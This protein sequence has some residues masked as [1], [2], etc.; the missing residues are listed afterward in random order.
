MTTLATTDQKRSLHQFLDRMGGE[1]GKVVSSHMT[2]ETMAALVYTEAARVPAIFD[3]LK[4]NPGS[5]A[6]TVML[7]AQLG[8]DVSGPLGHFYLIPR[9][10]KLDPRDKRRNAPKAM[11]LTYIIG[12]KGF[13]ELAR[14]SDD[15]VRPN[16]GVV[17]ADELAE[18]GGRF[19]WKDEP[20]ECDH[21]RHWGLKRKDADIVGAYALV[22]LHG[23]H[24]IQILLDR[25]AIDDRRKRAMSDVF[26]KRDFAAMARKSAIRSLMNGGEVPLTPALQKAVEADLASDRLNVLD[27]SELPASPPAVDPLRAKLGLEQKDPPKEVEPEPEPEV[28]DVDVDALPLLEAIGYLEGQLPEELREEAA[29]AAKLNPEA[30]LEGQG[31]AVEA[32]RVELKKRAD[33]LNGSK[34]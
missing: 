7:A 26:W 11:T 29:K 10:M 8:L 32:Y 23:G 34:S 9:K 16:S 24:R 21:P 33:A 6:S 5:V 30:E 1:I 13:L 14:R 17:Y 27:V 3:C 25:D 18:N 4:E 20:P 22:D 12:Y 31:K 15:I 2:A 28:K 19:H